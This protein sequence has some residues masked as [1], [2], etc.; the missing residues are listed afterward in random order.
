MRAAFFTFLVVRA[1]V[2]AFAE[3]HTYECDAVPTDAGWS[4]GLNWCDPQEWAAAGSFY[5]YVDF[6][7]GFD[8]PQGKQSSYIYSLADFVGTEEFWFEFVVVT[9]GD[10]AELISVA[11]V[12]IVLGNNSARYQLIIS[13]DQVR[14]IRDL[15]LGELYFDIEPGPHVYRV[16]VFGDELYIVWVDGEVVDTG[17]PEQNPYP[18]LAP[19]SIIN[20]RTKAKLVEST[21][22]WSYIRWGQLQ[23]TGSLDF[24]MDGQVTLDDLPFF[25][26]CLTSSAGSWA[27]CAWADSDESGG[28]DC[29]DWSAFLVAWTSPDDPP[30]EPQCECPTDLSADGTTNASDLAQLLGV[31]GPN[32]GHPADFNS[33]DMVNASDLAQLLG[34]WGSCD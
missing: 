6:C 25:H 10:S 28:V 33:D 2:S 34:S 7:P 17:L 30:T 19:D 11:P 31:W 4:V 20:F 26:E 1:S 9:D 14:F 13:D 5:Q 23:P 8:P 16:E 27:G 29:T 32:A 12:S 15:A 18:L 22:A 24:T 3:V 21:S